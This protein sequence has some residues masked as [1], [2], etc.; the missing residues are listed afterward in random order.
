MFYATRD[1]EADFLEITV[2]G[3]GASYIYIFQ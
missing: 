1:L 2:H 3:D